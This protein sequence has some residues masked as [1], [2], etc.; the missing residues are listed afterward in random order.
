M[1]LKKLQEVVEI[2]EMSVRCE[3]PKMIEP[4]RTFTRILLEA[5]E[6]QIPKRVRKTGSGWKQCPTCGHVFARQERPNF[7]ENCGQAIEWPEKK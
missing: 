5:A 3:H 2:Y 7:C 6:K 4:D 1:D